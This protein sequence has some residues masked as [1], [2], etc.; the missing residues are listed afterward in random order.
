MNKTQLMI[1]KPQEIELH[2]VKYPELFPYVLSFKT[3]M[4]KE[5]RQACYKIRNVI[6]HES[7]WAIYC[8]IRGA[9]V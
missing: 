8:L 7:P 6:R 2:V 4:R 3:R 1:Q 5:S 9:K